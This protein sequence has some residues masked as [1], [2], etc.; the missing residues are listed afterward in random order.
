MTPLPACGARDAANPPQAAGIWRAMAR[1]FPLRPGC[2]ALCA[3]ALAC[4][5]ALARDGWFMTARGHSV[6]TPAIDMLDCP[7]MERVLAGIDATGYRK[8]KR[9]PSDHADMALFD[10]EH[11]L[12]QA[13]FARCGGSAAPPAPTADGDREGVDADP[14]GKGY[15]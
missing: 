3:A 4:A 15:E 8:G 7:R 6:E 2:A 1:C 10:Y 12:A 14:F 11:R 9:L 5:P 13:H